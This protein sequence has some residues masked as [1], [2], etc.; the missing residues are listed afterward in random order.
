[1]YYTY[2]IYKL[3]LIECDK[4]CWGVGCEEFCVACVN[5]T[6][7]HVNGSCLNSCVAG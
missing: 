3:K 2:A 7:S 1:M 5:K 6:C 4:G